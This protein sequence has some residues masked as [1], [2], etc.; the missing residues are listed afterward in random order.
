MILHDMTVHVRSS[1]HEEF[2]CIYTEMIEFPYIAVC[3][4]S[5]C[6]YIHHVYAQQYTVVQ[7]VMFT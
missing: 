1:E 2:R 3:I 4:S 7:Y 6:T 5:F